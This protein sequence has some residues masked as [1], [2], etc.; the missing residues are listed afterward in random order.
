[1]IGPFR[2]ERLPPLVRL[3][4]P[5]LRREFPRLALVMLVVMPLSPV[6]A[7][8]VPYLTKVAIDSY[9]IPGMA[10]GDIAPYRE[11][12]VQLVTIGFV[13][14]VAGYLADAAYV[15]TLQ[16]AGQRLIADLRLVVYRRTLRL[17]RAFFDRHPIGAILTRVTSDIEALG[18]ALAPT[19]LSMLVDIL[20]AVAFL[21]MMF[22]LDWRLTL[23]LLILLPVLVVL[24][25]FFQVRVRATFFRTRQALSEATGYLQE[26]L[27]GIKTIQLF[28]AEEQAIANYQAR[29]LRF[30]QAQNRSNFYDALL[31][32]LVEGLTSLALALVL[33]AAAGSLL[34][35]ALTLGTLVAFMEYIQRLFVPV[36]EFSQQLAVLQRSMAALDHI[37]ELCEAPIDPAEQQEDTAQEEAAPANAPDAFE[38]LEFRDVR[39]A[40]GSNGPEILKGIS[41]TVRRGE[42]L[43]IV[44]ATGSGKSTIIRLISRAYGGYSGS[45]RINGRELGTIPAGELGR[46]IA[47]V[48]QTVFLYRGSVAF[49]IALEREG[50]GEDAV[51]EAARYVQAD[52][53]ISRLEE[54]YA[55]QVRQG[56][57]NLSAG[58]GQLIAFARAVAGGSELIVLDEATS[59]VDSMTEALIQEAVGRLY[60]DKTVIAIAHRL[61]TIRSAD[62]ILV[63]EAGR[64]VEHGNHAHLMALGGHYASLVQAQEATAGPP[65][66]SPHPTQEPTGT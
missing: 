25:R 11:G 17:P 13:V 8:L 6:M 15:L 32:S 40:Y 3:I 51:R 16:R 4:W 63:M 26:C 59:S 60:R 20:K 29:N 56:G 43:A 28:G 24:I 44:G 54:G 34:A 57:E 62:N 45:I 19:M 39:F 10:A 47:T 64:V 38:S 31:Y 30:F 35:G 18:D 41:F 2:K 33:W 55:T 58:Q 48:H 7:M 9:I 22:F 14:V 27:S 61:S 23:I 66:E 12:L 52:P 1:M 5:S 36:K 42:A 37:N 65:E 49:N 50:V 53:F 21:G 46:M